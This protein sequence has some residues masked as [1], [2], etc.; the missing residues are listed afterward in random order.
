[1]SNPTNLQR[2]TEGL[3]M[4]PA[5]EIAAITL[6]ED[7]VQTDADGNLSL[8]KSLAVAASQAS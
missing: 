4:V 2:E 8:S 7:V 3:G 5:T 6:P 1:M